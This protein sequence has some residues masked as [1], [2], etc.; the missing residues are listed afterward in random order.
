MDLKFQQLK[1]IA[2][3]NQKMIPKEFDVQF[4]IKSSLPGFMAF[5]STNI[6]PYE[7]DLEEIIRNKIK[8]ENYKEETLKEFIKLMKFFLKFT[9]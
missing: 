4:L 5:L 3:E 9:F 8:D 6:K 2:K 1:Q 7:K